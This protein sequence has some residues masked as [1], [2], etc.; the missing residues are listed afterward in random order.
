MSTDILLLIGAAV[1]LVAVIVAKI[2]DRLG[3]PALLL[4]LLLGVVIAAPS[5]GTLFTDATLAHDLGFVALVIILAEGGLS[6]RWRDIRPAIVPA[7]LLATVAVGITIVLVAAFAHLVLRLP[8]AISVLVA[9]IMAPTDSAAVFSVLRHA[10][11]PPRVRAMLEGESGLNDAP[12]V[13]LV[14][15]A[16]E[17]AMGTISYADLPLTGLLIVGELLGGL[18]LGAALGWLGIQL[19]RNL[20]LPSSGLYP[21][22][23]LGWAII[24]YG[25][26]VALHVSG[27][28]A[29][30][31]CAVFLS[32]GK[33]PHRHATRSFVE[34]IGWIAQIGLFV[35]LGLLATPSRITWVEV[36]Q[37]T[38]LGLFLT[39]VARPGSVAAV[40]TPLKVPW[41]EQAFISWAGLRGA[42]PI[43]L[44][45]I[46]MSAGLPLADDLFDI[47]FVAV[48]VLTLL[49]APS[50][51]WLAKRLDLAGDP[52]EVDIEVAP[53]DQVDADLLQLRISDTS[54]MHGVTVG[55]L[56]LPRNAQVSLVIRGA[57]TFTPHGRDVLREGDE[58]LIVTPSGDRT[59]VENRLRAIDKGGRLARWAS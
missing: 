36:V 13:L 52:N 15:A 41:R 42:V 58:L 11:L 47:V 34:G 44:A 16:T 28:A 19:L 53:L 23:S 40:L 1:V 33:L 24:A 37:A 8:L 32:N 48:I 50:L 3:V 27:F 9:A 21:L 2:G 55:E 57:E 17:L 6:T 7:V 43:I 25:T 45:T 14:I 22:A 26:G 12:T 4:F 39:F 49:N 51:P 59:T 20:A 31:T 30:Y 29:V 46:P 54:R 35:M 5:N 56:R 18:A 38:I 10:S